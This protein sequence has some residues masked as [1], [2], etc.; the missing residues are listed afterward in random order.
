MSIYDELVIINPFFT[1]K[2]SGSG[3]GLAV[4]YGIIQ[5][6]QGSIKADSEVGRGTT[7]TVVL[8]I[9]SNLNNPG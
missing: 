7:F 4:T 9:S 5:Q 6:H 1:T 2:E 8:P 3:L